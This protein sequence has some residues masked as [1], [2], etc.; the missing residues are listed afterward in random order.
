MGDRFS[1]VLGWHGC[2]VIFH[3]KHEVFRPRSS[4]CFLG[5]V[6]AMFFF[7]DDLVSSRL[8]GFVIFVVLCSNP[9]E[10]MVEIK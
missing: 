5:R 9:Y 4:H 6:R 10:T 1:S 2:Y 7:C 8:G 3:I